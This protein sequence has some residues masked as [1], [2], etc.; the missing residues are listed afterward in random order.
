MFFEKGAFWGVIT[1]EMIREVFKTN[2]KKDIYKKK[3]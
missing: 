1:E 3:D 2:G